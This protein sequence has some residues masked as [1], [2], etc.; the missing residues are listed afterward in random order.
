AGT[1]AGL[2]TTRGFEDTLL[3]ARARA[4]WLGLSETE[5]KRIVKTEKPPPLIPRV[6]TEGIVERIDADGRVVTPLD[7]GSAERAI[8]RLLA[9]GVR[10]LAISLLWSFVN[11]AH[12]QAV[13]ALA[14]KLA[15]E[16][17]VTTGAELAPY[18]GEYERTNTVAMNACL[19]EIAGRY[20]ATLRRLLE[21][22]GLRAPLLVTQGYGGALRAEVAARNAVGLIES[23]PASGMVASRYVG[24]AL[25]CRNIIATDMGGTTFK[26]GLIADGLLEQGTNPTLARY[27]VLVPKIHVESIGA[28]GGSIAWLAEGTGTLQ[29]GPRSAGALPGP[30][31][32][33]R[34]GSEPT[35]TDAD[36]VLGYL[37]PAFFLGGQM[38]LE[39]AAAER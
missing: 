5:I 33:G 21:E 25:G 7:L 6:L 39:R 31:C 15:P 1:R 20:L 4:R 26:V 35:V 8:R 3:I 36:L 12:E 13:A 10:S 37:N 38:R 18:E 17:F 34:G 30:A 11:P 23:G 32:Y 2:I 19:G 29:V 27:S 14:A 24:A 22:E 9:A 16:L 28:G